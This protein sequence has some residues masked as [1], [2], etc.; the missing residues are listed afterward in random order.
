VHS[1]CAIRDSSDVTSDGTS[2]QKSVVCADLGGL[3][4][5]TAP[6]ATEEMEDG[7]EDADL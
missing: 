6:A 1:L 4:S 3:F 2:L 5:F 7:M